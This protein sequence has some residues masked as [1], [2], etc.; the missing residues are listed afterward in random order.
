MEVLGII[1]ETSWLVV[2][3]ADYSD[4]EAVLSCVAKFQIY[5][6]N[7]IQVIFLQGYDIKQ[8]EDKRWH[9]IL[10]HSSKRRKG[11]RLNYLAILPFLLLPAL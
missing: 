1:P 7:E 3:H 11:T 8:N 6:L 10:K 4:N 5:A 2:R 9:K